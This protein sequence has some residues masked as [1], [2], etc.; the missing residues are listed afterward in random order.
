MSVVPV[1]MAGGLGKRMN[2]DIPKVCHTIAGQPMI[3][4][5]I[6][7]AQKLQPEKILVVV[8]KYKDIIVKTL[9]EAKVNRVNM[10]NVV[11]VDQNP[12]LGTGHAL[13]CCLKN[14]STLDPNTK[15]LI[16]SGDVPFISLDIM[17]ML[18]ESEKDAAIATADVYDPEGYGRVVKTID[19]IFEKIVEEKDCNDEQKE[20]TL[21]NCG[22][23]S[24]K[25]EQLLYSL[26]KLTNVNKQ[27]EYYL[28][29]IFSI[30]KTLEIVDGETKIDTCLID[31]DLQYQVQGVN[32]EEQ[33][34]ELEELFYEK[35]TGIIYKEIREPKDSHESTVSNE[36]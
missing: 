19:G 12:A 27:R 14:L 20:I 13:Q 31:E 28:T 17:K 34:K 22:V 30:I 33:L 6:E 26:P 35:H 7:T 21:V 36:V 32:T 1:I 11:F 24:V 25:C 29:D 5:V 4:H 15:I 23:Y 2:S 3:A 9:L 16:L 18:L 10:E 8:G